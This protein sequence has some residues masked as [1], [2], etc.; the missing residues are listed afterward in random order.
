MVL[1]SVA[2]PHVGAATTQTRLQCSMAGLQ[3]P[4]SGRN[5]SNAPLQRSITARNR[6]NVRLQ[7]REYSQTRSVAAKQGGRGI[8][9]HYGVGNSASWLYGDGLLSE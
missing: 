4:I 1:S 8:L 9:Q 2:M 6:V 7:R 3:Q 5:R